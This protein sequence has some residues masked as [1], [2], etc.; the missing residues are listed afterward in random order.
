MKSFKEKPS[1]REP[2]IHKNSH[3][4][5]LNSQKEIWTF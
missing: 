3:F 5:F 2:T 1:I 4:D